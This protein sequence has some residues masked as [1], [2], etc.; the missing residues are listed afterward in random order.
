MLTVPVSNRPSRGIFPRAAVIAAELLAI[1]ALAL[2]S[3]KAAWFIAYGAYSQS[4]V[5]SEPDFRP[6]IRE[7]RLMPNATSFDALFEGARPATPL[8]DLDALPETQLGLRLYGVRTGEVPETGSAIVE[9][10]ANGQRAYSVGQS[11]TGDAVLAAVL[12]DRIVI[13]RAGVR[14]VLFLREPETN[15]VLANTGQSPASMAPE[16]LLE[17]LALQPYF[18]AGSMIGLRVNASDDSLAARGVGLE[19][20]DI[21]LAINGRDM[22]RSA[23][24][25]AQFISTLPQVS[26]LQLTV[27]RNGEPVILDISQ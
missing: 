1:A 2:V 15:G 22:P 9:V 16:A 24:S 17:G 12:A 4:F 19:R 13:E 10:G 26:S 5:F 27:R 21:I 8:T 25:A 7:T 18:E 3:A 23:D 11:I 14:E 6:R 20:G